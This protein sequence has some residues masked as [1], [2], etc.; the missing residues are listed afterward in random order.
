MQ[1]IQHVFASQLEG[2]DVQDFTE[3]T[4][5]SALP[6]RDSF[7]LQKQRESL[8]MTVPKLVWENSDHT[9]EEPGKVDVLFWE[10]HGLMLVD[11]GGD[12]SAEE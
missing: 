7:K 1:A 6:R 2:V 8:T 12:L 4:P 11:V 3:N 10:E 9:L 5:F